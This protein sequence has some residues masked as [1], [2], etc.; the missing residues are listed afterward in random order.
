MRTNQIM[1]CTLL[2]LFVILAGCQPIQPIAPV[3]DAAQPGAE[4]GNKTLVLYETGFEPPNF[5]LGKLDGQRGW[6]QWVGRAGGATIADT[7]SATGRQALHNDGRLM[8]PVPGATWS[9]VINYYTVNYNAIEHKTPVLM[10]EA[11]V[12]LDG[13]NMDNDAGPDDRVSASLV[14]WGLYG[15]GLAFNLLLSTGKVQ[16]IREGSAPVTLGEYHRLGLKLDFMHQTAEYFLDG[17]SFGVEPFRDT[18]SAV[19]LGDVRL[20]LVGNPTVGAQYTASYDN[21]VVRIVP[22]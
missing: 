20:D 9:G 1:H 18:H 10:I 14:A 8:T 12:R 4:I 11:D 16:T 21:L 5:M 19:G 17:V 3:A 22:P 2:A 13:P 6:V 15:E 7:T